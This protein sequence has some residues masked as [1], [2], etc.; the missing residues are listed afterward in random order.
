MI[1]SLLLLLSLV[2]HARTSSNNNNNLLTSNHHLRAAPPST[3]TNTT[4]TPPHSGDPSSNPQETLVSSDNNDP[5]P[6]RIGTARAGIANVEDVGTVPQYH[7]DQ[8]PSAI[9]IVSRTEDAVKLKWSAP[10]NTQPV[11]YNLL[12]NRV[13][14][15]SGPKTYFE[16]VGLS[17]EHCYTFQVAAYINGRW[18][19]FS[20]AMRVASMQHSV[21]VE[22]IDQGIKAARGNIK[23]AAQARITGSP[24]LLDGIKHPSSVN[25]GPGYVE[26]IGSTGDFSVAG[27][28]AS[29]LNCQVSKCVDASSQALS[30]IHP[31][32]GHLMVRLDDGSWKLRFIEI[33]PETNI[34]G[35]QNEGH[36]ALVVV[37]LRLVG[38]CIDQCFFFSS[39]PG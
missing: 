39:L 33:P 1:L 34:L 11:M 7:S 29:V 37:V 8:G 13:S 38:L 10:P 21:D 17:P 32:I 20:P 4:T 3:T 12:M 30:L 19:K 35:K 18:T 15:Y 23:K 26:Y 9:T 36:L 14:I 6:A 16:E 2:P 5:P 24:C 25:G 28:D 31:L 27:V 22:K